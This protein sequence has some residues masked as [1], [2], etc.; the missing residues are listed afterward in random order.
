MKKSLKNL[1]VCVLV[2]ICFQT[3]AIIIDPVSVQHKKIPTAEEV[4][5]KQLQA[6]NSRDLEGFVACFSDDVEVL[7][8]PEQVLYQGK[9][10]LRASYQSFFEN[11]PDLYCELIDRSVNGNKVKDEIKI[12]RLKKTKPM[13]TTVM[14]VVEEGLITKMYFVN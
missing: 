6:Y 7:M 1:S 4:V 10:Q 12:T 2:L 14:Y 3:Q 13:K 11:T 8:F 9:D 5:Q